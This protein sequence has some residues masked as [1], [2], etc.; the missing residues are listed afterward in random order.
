MSSKSCAI[1]FEPYNVKERMPKFLNC[2]HTFCNSCLQVRGLRFYLV[3][4][5][6]PLISDIE[7]TKMT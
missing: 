3:T 1:C 6:L 4:N 5:F 7:K 2:F